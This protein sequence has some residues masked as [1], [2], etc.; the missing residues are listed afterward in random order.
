MRSKARQSTLISFFVGNE[1]S[2]GC[3]AIHEQGAGAGAD[4]RAR[5]FFWR[6]KARRFSFSGCGFSGRVA[7]DQG[8][9]RGCPVQS[10]NFGLILPSPLRL[11]MKPHALRLPVLA[12]ALLTSCASTETDR[13]L[14][15]QADANKD[16]KLSL[17]E[18]NKV[19]LPRLFNRF[20]RNGDGHVTLEE[21]RGVEPGFDAKVF[22]ERDLNRDGKVT[23]AESEKV[24][25]SKGGL[26]K[27]FAEVDTNGDGFIDQA[28]A[29][30]HTAKLD[31]QT[32]TAP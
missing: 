28:E 1:V 9:L 22:E 32:P 17:N 24:A 26:K 13:D 2:R 29:E 25:L 10:W 16:G 31:Q 11:L 20:D 19:G 4:I 23:Y 21:V 18:V 5:G 6:L 30:A 8:G 7:P 27:Q 15:L 3:Q 14:F 12:A